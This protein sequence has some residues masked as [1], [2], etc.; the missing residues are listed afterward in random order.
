MDGD[1]AVPA[2]DVK[3]FVASTAHT[4]R[5]VTLPK[6]PGRKPLVHAGAGPT[7]PARRLSASG[8][9][10][11]NTPSP[12]GVTVRRRCRDVQQRAAALG[13]VEQTV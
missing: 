4:N 9:G 6:K 11:L 12:K 1:G 3:G 8:I 2:K 5:E 10:P 13:R 7:Q